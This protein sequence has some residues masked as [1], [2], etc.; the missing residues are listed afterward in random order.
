MA[1]GSVSVQHPEVPRPRY[2]GAPSALG[3]G[4]DA[5]REGPGDTEGE[6]GAAAPHLPHGVRA[7]GRPGSSDHAAGRSGTVKAGAQAPGGAGRGGPG[8]RM[9]LPLLPWGRARAGTAAS[10]APS[11]KATAAAAAAL[12]GPRS[13]HFLY[14]S[15]RGFQ[16]E[17]GL[18]GQ[19]F[20]FCQKPFGSGSRPGAPHPHPRGPS[21]DPAAAPPGLGR[22]SWRAALGRSAQPRG[23][24]CAAPAA[25]GD[26]GEKLGEKFAAWWTVPWDARRFRSGPAGGEA[27]SSTQSTLALYLLPEAGSKCRS[28]AADQ[29]QGAS[30]TSLTG[31]HAAFS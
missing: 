11:R 19:G 29:R 23:A 20:F 10:P 12:W 21:E 15:E 6:G 18:G 24:A 26:R 25:P 1:R 13:L 28:T 17:V 22:A 7:L 5:E 30:S 4:R 16:E 8:A 31:G 2:S 9:P 27:E 3:G 14:R